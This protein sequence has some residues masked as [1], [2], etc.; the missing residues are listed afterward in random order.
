MAHAYDTG[1]LTSQRQ[2][3]R[4]ALLA[5][6]A[7]LVKTPLGGLYVRSLKVI[8]GQL[9]GGSEEGLAEIAHHTQGELPAVLIALGGKKNVSIGSDDLEVMGTFEVKVYA[10]SSHQ[11]DDVV[12]RLYTDAIA[13]A[14]NRAD[15]GIFT[16]LE[17]IEELLVGQE[18]DVPGV[19]PMLETDDRELAT[20]ADLTVWEQTYEVTATKTINPNR[21]LT[22]LLLSIQADHALD[23]P[24]EVVDPIVTTITELDPPE[25]P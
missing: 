25:A 16:M 23:V 1:L 19:G 12:G 14:S 11:K 21:G 15:P 13:V 5:K 4:D 10:A 7:P 2:A 6:L 8:P 18:L 9:S 17:H 22:Q 20:F 3:I 24:P